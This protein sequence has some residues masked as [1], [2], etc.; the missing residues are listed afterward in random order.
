MTPRQLKRFEDLLRLALD[1]AA[2]EN[3]REVALQEALRTVVAIRV[4]SSAELQWEKTIVMRRQFCSH[5][6]DNIRPAT[7]A[8]RRGDEFQHENCRQDVNGEAP[9]L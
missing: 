6:A 8:F 5:C 7:R 1:R 3:E 9:K 4:G 2:S